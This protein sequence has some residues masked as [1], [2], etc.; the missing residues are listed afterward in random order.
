MTQLPDTVRTWQEMQ[1]LLK[2]GGVKDEEMKWAGLLG[3]DPKQKVSREEIAQ[4]FERNFPQVEAAWKRKDEDWQNAPVVNQMR[5]NREI[6]E[7]DLTQANGEFLDSAFGR[8]IRG[9]PNR[10]PVNVQGYPDPISL[11]DLRNILM[12]NPNFDVGLLDEHMRV[13]ALNWRE[14]LQRYNQADT[15]YLNSVRDFMPQQDLQLG[16]QSGKNILTPVGQIIQNLS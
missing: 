3:Y 16:R 13:P 2:Q 10:L 8:D 9:N 14:A 7:R 5:S 6:A 15:Q 1:S 11:V 12:S 4:A